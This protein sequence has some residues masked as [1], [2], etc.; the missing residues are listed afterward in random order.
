MERKK[1]LYCKW[2]DVS[3][4]LRVYL[5]W[6]GYAILFIQITGYFLENIP[7]NVMISV[8]KIEC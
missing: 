1:M 2:S 6:N 3:R 8:D 4:L 7:N 5:G